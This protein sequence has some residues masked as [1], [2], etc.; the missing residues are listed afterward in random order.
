MLAQPR[1]KHTHLRK[2]PSALSQ[3]ESLPMI[4]VHPAPIR[5]RSFSDSFREIVLGG[6]TVLIA[7]RAHHVPLSSARTRGDRTFVSAASYRNHRGQSG[8]TNIIGSRSGGRV[9]G[10]QLQ[11]RYLRSRHF[12]ASICASCS[13]ANHYRTAISQ[14]ALR[15]RVSGRAVAK[16]RPTGDICSH[17]LDRAA[18]Q[19]TRRD[20]GPWRGYVRRQIYARCDRGRA[21]SARACRVARRGRV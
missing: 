11:G 19:P 2:S 16:D 10:L 8:R 14:A 15:R 3:I 5:L 18:M 20:R 1:T 13:T 21:P 9:A 4:S 7:D 12:F 17:C 6:G